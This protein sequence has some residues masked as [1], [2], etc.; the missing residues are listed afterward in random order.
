VRTG[1]VLDIDW[2]G[3][4]SVEYD[5]AKIRRLMQR[6]LDESGRVQPREVYLVY[7][8]G[9]SHPDRSLFDEFLTAL[10]ERV[11]GR[12]E[13]LPA[14]GGPPCPETTGSVLAALEKRV[15]LGLR[16]LGVY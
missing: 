15:V 8:A 5:L 1:E 2:D 9:Y 11:D 7:S 10:T 14:P 13:P 6:V 4:A 12:V 16:R 3:I